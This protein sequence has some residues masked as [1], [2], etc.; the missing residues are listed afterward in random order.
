[1]V[2][3]ALEEKEYI[4]SRWE[5]YSDSACPVGR[6]I[7]LHVEYANHAGSA[8]GTRSVTDDSDVILLLVHY[9]TLDTVSEAVVAPLDDSVVDWVTIFAVDNDRHQLHRHPVS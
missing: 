1:M 5:M 3:F 4:G 6:S 9:I 8:L 7:S 2:F